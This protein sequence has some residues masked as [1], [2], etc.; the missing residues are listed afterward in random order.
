MRMAGFWTPSE[1]TSTWSGRRLWFRPA[2]VITAFV[3]FTSPLSV[4]HREKQ[5]QSA[6]ALKNGYGLLMPA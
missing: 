3:I 1:S 5:S 2:A 6:T 4:P